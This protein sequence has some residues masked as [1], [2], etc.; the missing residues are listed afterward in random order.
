[1]APGAEEPKGCKGKLFQT[2][3]LAQ[4][5]PEK[6]Q[7][8]LKKAAKLLGACVNKASGVWEVWL[9]QEDTV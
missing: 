6:I 7:M 3:F 5:K 1:M 4:G 2:R 8:H 9:L